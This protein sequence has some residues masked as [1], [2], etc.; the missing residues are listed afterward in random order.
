MQ[1]IS[2]ENAVFWEGGVFLT[3]SAYLEFQRFGSLW[4]KLT[5]K[6]PS[7]LR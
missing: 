6:V 7:H 4:D 3:P 1:F 5:F 2:I